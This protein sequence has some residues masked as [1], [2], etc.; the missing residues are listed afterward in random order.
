MPFRD[1]TEEDN[2]IIV[3]IVTIGQRIPVQVHSYPAV[4]ES[5]LRLELPGTGSQAKRFISGFSVIDEDDELSRMLVF[6]RDVFHEFQ[7]TV[8]RT[9]DEWFYDVSVEARMSEDVTPKSLAQKYQDGHQDVY[10]TIVRVVATRLATEA[11][12][13]A[14][15]DESENEQPPAMILTDIMRENLPG[16]YGYQVTGI[17]IEAV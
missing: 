1:G 11:H 15:L 9:V 2:D 4:D 7:I 16:I 14:L 8:H 6:H 3:A 5:Q 12:R 13:F 17:A 10:A